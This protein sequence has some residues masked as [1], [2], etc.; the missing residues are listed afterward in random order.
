MHHN[1]RLPTKQQAIISAATSQGDP[2]RKAR[3]GPE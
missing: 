3:T 1:E 2:L